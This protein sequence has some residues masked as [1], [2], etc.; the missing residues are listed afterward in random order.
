MSNGYKGTKN[1][2][3]K[4][5]AAVKA[6]RRENLSLPNLALFRFVVIYSIMRL[7]NEVEY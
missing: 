4:K 6:K 3:F 7:T 2:W 5:F 1:I